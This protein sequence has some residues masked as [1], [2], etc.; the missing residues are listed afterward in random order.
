MKSK[1]RLRFLSCIIGIVVG[2][3]IIL[4][5]TTIGT[6]KSLALGDAF[7]TKASG[8]S[9]VN[10]N[11]A[12]LGAN[13]NPLSFNLFHVS[14]DA[15]NN[16]FSPDYYNSLMGK[17][18]DDDDKKDLLQRIPDDQLQFKSG[19][20]TQLPLFSFSIGHFGFTPQVV[21][22][23]SS[24]LSK[25]LLEFVVE[26]I[27][28]TEYN[29]SD[30]DGE[31]VAFGEVKIGYGHKL[32]LENVLPPHI[33]PIYGGINLGYMLGIGYA[34]VMDM[35]SSFINSIDGMQLDNSIKI[36]TAGYN[37]EEEELSVI[38][39]SGMRLDIG[40]FSHITENIDVGLAIRNL[41]AS[42]KW[43]DNC[44]EHVISVYSDSSFNTVDLMDEVDSL[45]ID[46]DTTYT[47]GSITQK[48]PVELH[49][50]GSYKVMRNLNLYLDYV[51]GFKNS[52]LTSSKPKFS[53]GCEY[54]PI[55]WLPIRAGI[56]LGGEK[57]VHFSFGSGVEL[58]N[59][60]FSWGIRSYG[61][62]IPIHTKGTA[63]ALESN[64]R[65]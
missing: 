1:I 48:I 37:T 65:F 36:Q 20:G 26:D 34:K 15:S 38:A 39:G 25:R 18:L 14:I 11:P 63:I 57:P 51:Q 49:L 13:Y 28:F 22:G 24:G 56:G 7:I 45:I 64:I 10:W 61:S 2:L 44:E 27:E 3:P 12:N 50:G 62:P 21:I 55:A 59:F 9:A 52:T 5:A 42:I 4:S 58:R 6:A 31:V 30:T 40:F 8:Y 47:I 53:L 60:E 33:P 46:T 19:L 23:M 17:Y 29:F 32:P 16:S 35:E 54:Y 43:D 41:F